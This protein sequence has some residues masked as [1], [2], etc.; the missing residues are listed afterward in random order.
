MTVSKF[1]LL[2]AFSSNQTSFL[3]LI[4][5]KK[6]GPYVTLRDFLWCQGNVTPCFL[7]LTMEGIKKSTG[8][9]RTDYFLCLWSYFIQFNSLSLS[10]LHLWSKALCRSTQTIK[11]TPTKS[12]Q[13]RSLRLSVTWL[14][15]ISVFSLGKTAESIF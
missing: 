4:W 11:P 5:L 6:N 3:N 10:L 7:A 9:C 8:F 12:S 14:Y 1:V 2:S 15:S 13:P